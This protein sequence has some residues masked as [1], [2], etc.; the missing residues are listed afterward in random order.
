MHILP[1]NQHPFAYSDTFLNNMNENSC[2]VVISNTI[3]AEKVNI[4]INCSIK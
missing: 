1:G 4:H 2:L 3:E